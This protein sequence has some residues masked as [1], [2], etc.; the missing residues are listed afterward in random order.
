MGMLHKAAG[1]TRLQGTLLMAGS[2]AFSP[3]AR[4]VIELGDAAGLR[5]GLRVITT[6]P[7]QKLKLA[8]IA[9]SQHSLSARVLSWLK[10]PIRAPS[11]CYYL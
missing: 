5:V 2:L 7:A 10:L 3:L 4:W 9:R 1:R 11:V 6:P 8:T